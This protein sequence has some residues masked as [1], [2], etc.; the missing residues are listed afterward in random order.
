MP[1]SSGFAAASALIL[2]KLQ[3]PVPAAPAINAFLR[4]RLSRRGIPAAS[5]RGASNLETT[6][7]FVF[8]KL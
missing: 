2:E 5:C 8:Y 3:A 6:K 4:R 7:A 1:I